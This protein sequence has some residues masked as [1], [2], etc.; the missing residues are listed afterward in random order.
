MQ[1]LDI[2]AIKQIVNTCP[3]GIVVFDIDQNI[4]DINEYGA[5]LLGV[6]NVR[7]I[8][9]SL[10]DYLFCN[11]GS[12][13]KFACNECDTC[14]T[15][16][17]PAI[18]ISEEGARVKLRLQCHKLNDSLSYAVFH[19]PGAYALTDTLTDALTRDQFFSAMN[20]IT[21]EFSLMF[22]DLNKF[23]AINDTHGHSTGDFVLKTIAKRIAN[24]LRDGDLFC[25]YGGDEFI[26]VLPN[27]TENVETVRDKLT[28]R[29]REPLHYENNILNISC[30]AGVAISTE[31]SSIDKLIHLADERMYTAKDFVQ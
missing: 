21:D 2:D 4:V 7:A 23:K 24:V 25:R 30:S 26:V 18:G 28:M 20:K 31:S 14:N 16:H 9:S 29:V 12:V 15:S 10:N 13:G 3:L 8:G 27:N 22:I 17:A 11:T 19:D 5:N 1:Q 6:D